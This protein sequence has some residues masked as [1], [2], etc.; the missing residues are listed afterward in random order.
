M[1]AP[2]SVIP[3]S[4]YRRTLGRARCRV[5]CC[6]PDAASL[7][8]RALLSTVAGSRFSPMVVSLYQ[9]DLHRNPRPAELRFWDNQLA[10]GASPADVASAIQNSATTGGVGTGDTNVTF[11]GGV[12]GT[13]RRGSRGRFPGGSVVSIPGGSTGVRYLGGIFYSNPSNS[14][15]NFPG[16]FVNSTPGST[17]VNFPGGFVNSTTGRTVV[18]F[19]GGSLNFSG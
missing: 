13:N 6:V 5:H 12:V 10:Q 15:V 18:N 17:L 16:G 19:P 2:W 11:P 14:V 3:A 4:R 7:E 9:A 1:F 8:A